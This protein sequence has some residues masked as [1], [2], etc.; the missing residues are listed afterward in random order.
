MLR[1]H[2]RSFLTDGVVITTPDPRKYNFS[3]SRLCFIHWM[4]SM[5]MGI[6]TPETCEPSIMSENG[7]HCRRRVLIYSRN[8]CS[9]CCLFGLPV[10]RKKKSRLSYSWTCMK[11]VFIFCKGKEIE[12]KSRINEWSKK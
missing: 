4:V 3:V 10:S 7:V 8:C 11:G 6:E 2:S 9:Y 5:A 1:T 12:G